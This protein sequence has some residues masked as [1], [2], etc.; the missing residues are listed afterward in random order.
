MSRRS[1]VS[2][3]PTKAVE[4]AIDAF[5]MGRMVI[6]VDDEDR[7]NEG[8]LALPAEMATPDA[9]N[10]MLKVA[11]GLVM[12]AMA[13]ELLDRF[14]LPMMSPRNTSRYGTAFTVSVDAREG[15]TTGISA[16]DR[17][18][19][20]QVLIAEDSTPDDLVV[21]GH[22]FP[23]RAQPGGVLKRAGQTEASVD[24]AR[25]AGL[26]PAAVLCQVMKEDGT[27]ARMEDL[28]KIST[29]LQIPILTVADLIAYR[30]QREL[31]V[32]VVGQCETNT[33]YGDFRCVIYEDTLTSTAHMALVR[34]EVKRDVPTLVRVHSEC[35][36]G[37]V[38][39]SLRCDCG[40]QLMAALERIGREGGVLLYLRQEGRGIGILNKVRAYA[41]Q[42]QGL[43]TVEANVRLGFQP[44]MRNYGIGAQI[45][46]HLGVGK[47][48]L[49][50]NN[51]RKMVGLRGYGLE[52]VER[53]PLQI[54][55][56]G[57]LVKRYL[58]AKRKKL[59]HLLDEV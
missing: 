24:L 48:R 8:D 20:I 5:R 56:R 27:M 25:L 40:P 6:L 11:S 17:A 49:L 1:R 10:T 44:D 45:L 58:E 59:G 54:R 30:M 13:P 41:L 22:V 36:T 4:R 16:F 37:D 39:H 19:T 28:K 33:P 57:P 32:R 38:F 47:M 15:T 51:P 31:L 12:V 55:P 43:D 9:I 14:E 18:R 42:D 35:L 3:S 52:I 29:E 21:P 34:G 50:T 23:L 26:K 46:A 7:E 2:K 53:V